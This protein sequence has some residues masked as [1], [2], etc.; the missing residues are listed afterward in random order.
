MSNDNTTLADVQP[1]GGVRLGDAAPTHDQQTIERVAKAMQ[2]SEQAQ[3]GWTWA[4]CSPIEVEGWMDLARAAVAAIPASQPVREQRAALWVQFAENGNIQF[5]TRDP[6]RAVE[7]SFCYAR[8]L[9]AY[10][11]KPF[12]IEDLSRFKDL[13]GFSAWQAIQLPET[14]PRRDFIRQS[15]ELIRIIDSAKEISK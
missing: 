3:S 7:Q 1:G 6:D 12:P 8:P 15:G 2:A 10:Y 5:F 11:E 14:D 13:I 4:D 9:T